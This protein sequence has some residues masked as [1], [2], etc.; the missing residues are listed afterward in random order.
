MDESLDPIAV[1]FRKWFRRRSE[2]IVPPIVASQFLSTGFVCE[3]RRRTQRWWRRRGKRQ[4]EVKMVMDH[5]KKLGIGID[6]NNQR[7]LNR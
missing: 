2:V 4:R 1:C 7:G 5:E 3:K 6:I